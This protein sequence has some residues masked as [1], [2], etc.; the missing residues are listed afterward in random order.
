MLNMKMTKYI[1]INKM[2]FKQSWMMQIYMLIMVV[3]TLITINSSSWFNAW[4]GMEINLMSFIPL[5]M[6]KSKN[7]ISNSMMIYF[8]IQASSSSMML[9]MIIMMKMDF[10]LNNLSFIMIII[11]FSL[12]MKLGAAPLHWWM[13]LIMMKLSWMNCFNLLT[14][15]KIAPLFLLSCSN[16][17][18]LLYTMMMI[19]TIMG[20]IMGLN[21]TSIK[22]ILVYSSINHL[23]W[24]LMIMM[25]NSTTMMMYF[26]MYSLM[27]FMICLTMNNLNF[28]YMNQLLINNNTKI[29]TKIML[30]TWFI[31][32]S[33]MPP[34]LGFLPKFIALT[35]MIKNNLFIE[36]TIFIMSTFVSLSF[37]MNP[38]MSMFINSKPENKWNKMNIKM[39]TMMFSIITVNMV[40]IMIILN[41]LLNSLM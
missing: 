22:L 9:I 33:G 25:L 7:K 1:K 26:I 31:S 35:L 24:M 5:M 12:L 13:P 41:P 38:C 28:N 39:Y 11:Q 8:I 21:Q 3:S 40:L 27:T 32:L 36:S 14:W 16:N 2:I 37:Y 23:G 10:Q 30:M 17:S 6:N 19:S 18:F 20:S 34:F 4:M 15:Q 29:Y